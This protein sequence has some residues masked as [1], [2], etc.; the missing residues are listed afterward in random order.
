MSPLLS[1]S[2]IWLRFYSLFMG[3]KDG[4]FSS[5]RNY[6]DN[7]AIN[8]LQEEEL[9]YISFIISVYTAPD[10]FTDDSKLQSHIIHSALNVKCLY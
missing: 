6:T 7:Q 5:L 9:S 8:L 4:D 10:R 2:F 3:N 1:Y